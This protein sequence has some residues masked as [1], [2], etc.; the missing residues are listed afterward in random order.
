MTKSLAIIAFMLALTEPAPAEIFTAP[1]EEVALGVVVLD[2]EADLEP[3]NLGSLIVQVF[4]VAVHHARDDD[5][6][7]GDHGGDGD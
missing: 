1:A 3:L 4:L 2:F 5:F 7:A 6:L